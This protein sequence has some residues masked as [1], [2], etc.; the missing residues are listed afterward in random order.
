M[1]LTI[2]FYFNKKS[3]MSLYILL[4]ANYL[5][6]WKCTAVMKGDGSQHQ[7]L[8]RNQSAFSMG[9]NNVVPGEMNATGGVRYFKVTPVATANQV[10][11]H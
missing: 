8:D 1:E 6:S 10:P 5:D 9:Q 3:L 11:W 2:H 4:A 7:D